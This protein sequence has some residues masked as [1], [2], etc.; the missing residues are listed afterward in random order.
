MSSWMLP[1]VLGGSEE[2]KRWGPRCTRLQ[3]SARLYTLSAV[4]P[5]R[6]PLT[7]PAKRK[8]PR[9]KIPVQ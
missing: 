3:L 7:N 6:C 1:L 2:V 4:R 5:L 9:L 8:M